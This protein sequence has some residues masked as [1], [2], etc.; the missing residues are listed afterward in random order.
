VSADRN[1]ESPFV[2]GDDD[3][4]MPNE[5]YWARVDVILDKLE[6]RGLLALV[7]PAYLG[8]LCYYLDQGWCDVMS[9]QPVERMSDFGTFLGR[10]Y[11]SQGNIIWIAG[12]DANPLGYEGM[13]ERVDALMS[14]ITAAEAGRH[15]IT[16]HGDRGVSAYE[17]FGAH[18][19]LSINSAY[20]GESCPDDTMV[21]QIEAEH[22]RSPVLPL[23]SIE[24]RFDAEGAD[25][26]CLADQF[27]WAALGG[28]V[29]HVYGN[30][31]TWTFSA[32]WDGDAG[33]SSP[34]ARVHTN[35]AK[36]IRSR[37]YWQ[38]VPDDSHEVVIAGYG[39]GVATVATSRVS[40]G[41]TVMAYVP[42]EGTRITVDMS[43]LSGFRATAYWYDP[44]TGEATYS[45]NYPTQGALEFVSPGDARVLVLDDASRGF[46]TPGTRDAPFRGKRP[47]PPVPRRLGA[48]R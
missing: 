45:G 33:I 17:Q 44:E 20:D 31:Y 1:G 27:L 30:R 26:V 10:R 14:A 2:T 8:Y 39:S 23:L 37:R 47:R 3:W 29:G 42:V 40:T 11:R 21:A 43:R 4:S 36:L 34:G 12:G 25:A 22:A 24:Q 38:F 32:G 18:S 13:D 41:E 46:P 28:A 48:L 7:T 5:A 6:A 9:S 19:W 35:S 16:G 15:L